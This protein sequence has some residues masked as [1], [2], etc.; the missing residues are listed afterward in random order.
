MSHEEG[1]KNEQ[2]QRIRKNIPIGLVQFPQPL[3]NVE[4][5][6]IMPTHHEKNPESY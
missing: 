6:Q 1:E 2:D 4:I 5:K 3:D